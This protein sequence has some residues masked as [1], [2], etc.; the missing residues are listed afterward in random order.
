M[1]TKEKW[2][3]VLPHMASRLGVDMENVDPYAKMKR[4]EVRRLQISGIFPEQ[5]VLLQEAWEKV[6]DF[7]LQTAPD[8]LAIS[9][10]P[11]LPDNSPFTA[12]IP[13]LDL[14]ASPYISMVTFDSIGQLF[15]ADWQGS[16]LQVRPD[17]SI[18]KRIKL[19]RP[20]VDFAYDRAGDILAL[21]IGDLYPNDGLYGAVAKLG[22]ADFSAP[23]LLFASLPR[24]VD[25]AQ[26]DLDGDGLEDLAICNFGNNL[27]NL[28]W[29]RNT[30]SG[31][32][33]KLIKEVPGA[34]RVHVRDLDG[35][36]DLDLAVL[37]AQGDEGVSFFYNEGGTFREE[38]ILRFPSLYGSNDLEVLDF[39]GDGDLDLVT[40]NGDNGD[41]SIIL[42]PYHGIRVFLNEQNDFREHF[43]YPMYGAS[44]VRARDFDLDG[45]VDLIAASFFPE[46]SAAGLDR[47]LVYLENQGDGRFTASHLPGADQG[48]WM[49]MDAGDLDRDGDVD[50][51]IGS[52]TLS[53]EGI[54]PQVLQEW[55]SSQ[56]H[57]LYLENQTK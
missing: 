53:N 13:E 23:N 39:D 37:F 31:Y 17:F 20:I 4:E 2:Q 28:S 41:Y 15:L 12:R 54:D 33:A 35:D 5:P 6:R 21:S 50:V 56:R 18:S 27:G 11:V 45:D 57:I 44:K 1:L 30:G 24:P 3:N 26:G 9:A 46:Q 8:S 25:F 19:P 48:R 52:F 22:G 32:E 29:Y 40:S 14:G 43:F 55:R 36:R 10:R 51:V 47:T 42:K 38:R 49:V 34:S 16:F 7:Y